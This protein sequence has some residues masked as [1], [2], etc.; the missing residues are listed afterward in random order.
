MTDE[1]WTGAQS[2]SRWARETPQAVAVVEGGYRYSYAEMGALVVRMAKHLMAMGLPPDA[3]AGIECSSRYVH[4]VLILACECLGLTTTSF[5]A[6]ELAA[7]TELLSRCAVLLTEAPCHRPQA[8]PLTLDLI[9]SIAQSP[10]SA[11]DFRLLAFQPVPDAAG[12]IVKTS[13]TTGKQKC[14]RNN[15]IGV[16][17]GLEVTRYMLDLVDG[18]RNFICVYQFGFRP[19][20][21][22][23]VLALQSGRTVVFSDVDAFHADP[24]GSGRLQHRAAAGG[25]PG[26]LRRLSRRGRPRAAML[27]PDQRRCPRR[28]GA[29]RAARDLRVGGLPHIFH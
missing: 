27:H 25:R 26:G 22:G 29:A 23:S 16:R 9:V 14:M 28:L 12:R 3:I 20:Y 7:D 24:R 2:L 8:V 13:G 6:P 15:S 18:S 17:R 11:E 10:I 4:L 1:P 19:S 21:T 5:V